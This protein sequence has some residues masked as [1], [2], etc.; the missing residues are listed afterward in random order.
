MAAL[1]SLPDAL[2]RADDARRPVAAPHNGASRGSFLATLRQ[3]EGGWGRAFEVAK[4]NTPTPAL[5]SRGDGAAGGA[6]PLRAGGE[7][8]RGRDAGGSPGV[9]EVPTVEGQA[10]A[11]GTAALRDPQAATAAGGHRTGHRAW[12]STSQ[13]LAQMGPGNTLTA[14]AWD[15]HGLDLALRGGDGAGG[16]RSAPQ[17]LERSGQRGVSATAGE[18]GLTAPPLP[19]LRAGGH[20]PSRVTSPSTLTEATADESPEPKGSVGAQRAPTRPTPASGPSVSV[21]SVQGGL[22]ISVW[23]ATGAQALTPALRKAIDEEVARHGSRLARLHYNGNPIH[24]P[25]LAGLTQE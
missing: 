11:T 18:S 14:P 17:A 13:A 22:A 15:A 10:A 12:S 21:T 8:G 24:H 6:N 9:Q 5:L 19:E 16:G 2:A 1:T 3:L 23:L 4:L 20:V 7:A 25:S